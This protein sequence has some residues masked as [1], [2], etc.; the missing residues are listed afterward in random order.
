MA[1]WCCARLA[2]TTKE[3]ALIDARPFWMQNSATNVFFLHYATM[4]IFGDGQLGQV[5]A[6]C[7]DGCDA[8]KPGLRLVLHANCWID[9]SFTA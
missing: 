1:D 5:R 2:P 7:D 8:P 9:A 3:H 6:G 4:G